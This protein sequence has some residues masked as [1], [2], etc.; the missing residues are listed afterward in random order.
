VAV[1]LE[2]IRRAGD[3]D[4]VEDALALEY[5]T[6]NAALRSH[7]LREGIR[8]QL[9]DK[10]GAPR[11]QEREIGKIATSVI[12]EYFAPLSDEPELYFDGN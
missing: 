9:I 3:L 10:D 7:D 5:R 2:A 6:S 8:A 1:T 12:E 4:S 11:W